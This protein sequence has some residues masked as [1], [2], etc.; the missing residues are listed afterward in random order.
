MKRAANASLAGEAHSLCQ[1][2]AEAEWIQLLIRN[3]CFG[4][5]PSSDWRKDVGPFVSVLRS[6]CELQNPYPGAHALDAKS[7]FDTLAKNCAGRKEDRRTA[8]DL[9][10]VRDSFS[11]RRSCARW[12][13]RLLNPTDIMTKSDVA[14]GS[15]ALSH[16]L[17]SGILTLSDADEER[18]ALQAE[19]VK[20]HRSKE[21]SRRYLAARDARLKAAGQS[22]RQ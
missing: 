13:P 3:A 18:G 22:G 16:M 19:G 4:E 20:Q 14:K 2:V 1:A 8:I 12:L 6:S 7:I 11:A 10:I 9:A 15:K 17:R 5:E 21:A